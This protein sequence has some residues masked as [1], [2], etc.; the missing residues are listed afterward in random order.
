MN[1]SGEN[2][3]EKRNIVSKIKVSRAC[4]Y[5]CF[6]CMRRRKNIQNFLLD[7]GMNIIC[8]KMDIFNIFDKMY[9]DEEVMEKV[10]INKNIKMSDECK[11]KLLSIDN[12]L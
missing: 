9:K 3:Q 2:E 8:E 11:I 10:L 6:C 5:L 12:Q 4:V 7:E 1:K